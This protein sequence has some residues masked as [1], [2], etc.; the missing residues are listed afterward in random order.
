MAT[1]RRDLLKAGSALFAGVSLAGCGGKLESAAPGASGDQS[2]GGDAPKAAELAVAAEWNVYR[3]LAA[4]ALALGLAGEFDAAAGVAADAFEKFEGAT[5]E[6]GAHEV[7]E[8][9]SEKRYSEFEEALGQLRERATGEN[10]EEMRVEADLVSKHLSAAQTKLVGEENARALD[11]QFLGT[12]LATASALYAAGKGDAAATIAGDTYEQF[13]QAAVHEDLET[14]DAESYEGF[15]SAVEAVEKAATAGTGGTVRNEANAA[16]DAAATGSYAVAASESAAGA[17][18]LAAI[19]ARGYDASMLASLGGPSTEF[20]HAAALNVYRAR[21]YD[22]AWLT[23]RGQSE[24]AKTAAEDIFAHF[25]GAEAHEAL[26]EADHE[27]YEGFETGL[28]D[29]A[30]AAGEGDAEAAASAADAVEKHL[31]AGISALATGTEAAVLQAAFFRARFGDARELYA[32]GDGKAAA[33]VAQGLFQRFERD[34]LG[35]HERLESASEDLYQSFEHEH[36]QEGLIPA[37]ENGNDDGVE[38][39]FAGVDDALLQFATK[40]ASE[41][42]VGAAESGLLSARGFDAAALAALGESKRARS[43]VQ[44]AFQHFEEGAG[45]FHEALEHADHT[46]YE[47]FEGALESVGSAAKDGDAYSS[48]TT[49]NEKALTALYTVVSNAGGDFGEAAASVAQ[50]AFAAFEEAE[51]HELLEKADR[52]AYESFEGKLEGLIEALKQGSGVSGALSAFARASLRAEFAV[53]GAPGK[54]P[55]GKSESSEGGSETQLSGGPNVVK[56]TP[57]DADHVVKLKAVSF[58]PAELTVSKGDKVAFVHAAGEP[59]SVTAYGDK[60]P[61]GADY[62]ASGDFDSQENAETGWENGKGAVQSG[63]SFVHTFETTGTHEFYCVPHEAA[64]MTGKIV[65]E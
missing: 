24:Y 26:E 11:L 1:N 8:T 16:F 64:G 43:V 15:E 55:V 18:H 45:G 3:A 53:A 39:H 52:D 7:L 35:F 62:W 12:R 60:I 34:E 27:A 37:F 2:A 40:V 32:L 5:G 10:V 57:D 29:L 63:Q 54:A 25:E 13:E 61:D 50:D 22:V 36:L 58:D 46:L 59:H 21:A 20:A 47:S 6:W 49:F 9:T 31:R 38:T 23:A 4:D 19:Q 44:S 17:G 30:S 42:R 28:E 33:S 56:G 41:A 48:A 65:V 51:V 14:A